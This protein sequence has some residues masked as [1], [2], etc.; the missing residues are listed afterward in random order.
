MSLAFCV[1][2]TGGARYAPLNRKRLHCDDARAPVRR[3][4]LSELLTKMA[5]ASRGT[6]AL[7]KTISQC[8]TDV[9]YAPVGGVQSL[10]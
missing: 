7:S 8:R 5:A 4:M 2:L 9:P 10:Y 6:S 1:W 3:W